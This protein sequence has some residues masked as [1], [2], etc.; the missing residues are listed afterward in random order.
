M[1]S[2]SAEITYESAS[3]QSLVK[4]LSV[5]NFSSDLWFLYDVYFYIKY[6]CYYVRDSY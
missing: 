6:V 1:P 3:L 2:Y 4:S 5:S